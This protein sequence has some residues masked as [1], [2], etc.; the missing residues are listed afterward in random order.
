MRPTN[1]LGACGHGLTSSSG[2]TSTIRFAS[3]AYRCWP[4]LKSRKSIDLFGQLKAGNARLQ[5]PR[6]AVEL[7]DRLVGLTQRVGGLLRR[8]AELRERFADLLRAGCLR[9]H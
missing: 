7:F 4:I 3:S 9:V 1:P 5:A 6:G 8:L 2:A